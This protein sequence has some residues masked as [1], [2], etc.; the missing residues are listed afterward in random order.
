MDGSEYRGYLYRVQCLVKGLHNTMA[1]L[2]D[3]SVAAIYKSADS[4]C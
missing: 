2:A 1:G 4:A 3:S